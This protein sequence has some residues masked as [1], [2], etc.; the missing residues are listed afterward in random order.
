MS[1]ALFLQRLGEN[2]PRLIPHAG[3]LGIRITRID[4][5]A[6]EARLPFRAEFLGDAERGIIH[7]GI[8]TTLIDSACGV[9]LLAHL[10]NPE[11]IATL[12]LRVDYLR[13]SLPGAEL[14][15][16]AECYR[17]SAQ[18]AFLRASVWQFDE[19]APVAASLATFMRSGSDKGRLG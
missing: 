14:V 12:D 8:V 3:A 7:T 11:K 9:A 19:A 16:R 17:L 18:I 10:G 13:P 6:V 1:T 5:A 15:C 2:F 4:A